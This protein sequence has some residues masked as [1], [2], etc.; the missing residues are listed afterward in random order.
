MIGDCVKWIPLESNSE[1]FN[2]YFASIG[3]GDDL[4]FHEAYTLDGVDYVQ[5]EIKAIIVNQNKIVGNEEIYKEEKF[6]LQDN[7][8]YY[9]IQDDT[10]YNACGLVA[11]LHAVLNCTVNLSSFLHC[12]MK[13]AGSS[14]S[15]CELLA[16]DKDL[17]SIHNKFASRNL[18]TNFPMETV[19]H[20]YVTFVSNDNKLYELDGRLNRPY[21]HK[22]LGSS[23]SLFEDVANIIKD[24]L[25]N[26]Q[27]SDD[28]SMLILAKVN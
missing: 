11:G 17:N 24:R 6:S 27:I 2:E 8:P 22:K 12:I 14:K 7:L 15:R 3:M 10:L 9:T 21:L 1:I 16:N 18:S 25:L 23:S 4:L 28:M 19:K 5:G 13:S 20:H 26:N